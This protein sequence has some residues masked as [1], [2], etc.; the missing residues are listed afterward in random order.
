MGF[1]PSAP[2]GVALDLA[3]NIYISDTGA[4]RLLE[5]A[6]SSPASDGFSTTAQ[7][8]SSAAIATNLVNT[9]SAAL[10]FSAIASANS[11]FIIGA[12]TCATT[13][14]VAAGASCTLLPEFTPQ[15]SGP[16]TGSITLTDNQLVFTLNT[17]GANEV[18]TFT[19]SGHKP[20]P[21]A[22]PRQQ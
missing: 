17:T 21:S 20:S 18:A 10:S 2:Q 7:G 8:S 1:A 22:A 11:N 3:G 13:S 9:G 6:V 14:T 4:E 5:L 15:T 12:G 19:T 16:L